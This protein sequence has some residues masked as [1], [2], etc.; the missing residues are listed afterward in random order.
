M[1]ATKLLAVLLAVLMVI[2][3]MVFPTAAEEPAQAAAEPDYG[4]TLTY[5][6][7]PL[8][9]DVGDTRENAYLV[10]HGGGKRNDAS[11]HWGGRNG[12][13]SG[14]IWR[15]PLG[16]TTATPAKVTIKAYSQCELWVL[17]AVNGGEY[18]TAYNCMEDPTVQW[19]PGVAWR[20]FDLTAAVAASMAT[21]D[22]IPQYVYVKLA[23]PAKGGDIGVGGYVVA[24]GED[25]YGGLFIQDS[26]VTMTVCYD[27]SVSENIERHIFH[28]NGGDD[29]NY[30]VQNNANANATG[31]FTDGTGRSVTFAYPL[32]SSELPEKLIWTA[33]LGGYLKLDFSVDNFHWVNFFD[34]GTASY[35]NP[36]VWKNFDLAELYAQE[37]EKYP[38]SMI[39]IKVSNSNPPQGWGGAIGDPNNPTTLTVVYPEKK[40]TGETITL[41]WSV[42]DKRCAGEDES[43]YWLGDVSF[44]G[45]Y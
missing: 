2:P 20:T 10:Q 3:A 44:N 40:L 41:D 13:G 45:G 16:N 17:A 6:F 14:T 4:I 26:E 12:E 38:S 43:L 35:I 34:Q 8:G 29:A 7:T 15:F 33:L 32:C 39:Y 24:A 31:Y 19:R 21:S 37:S 28:P 25:G 27:D 1:K 18:V 42:G 30:I 22:E 23:D 11:P 9:A 5:G 36:K